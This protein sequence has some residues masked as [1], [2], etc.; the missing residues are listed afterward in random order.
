MYFMGMLAVS[1]SWEEDGIGIWMNMEGAM[2][3]QNG[4][5]SPTKW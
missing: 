2:S 4:R 5:G 1:P 3:L